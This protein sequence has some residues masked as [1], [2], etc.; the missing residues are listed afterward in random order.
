MVR[1][2]QW[3][4]TKEDLVRLREYEPTGCFVAEVEGAPAGHVF[5]ISYQKLGWIGMLIIRS[6]YRRMGIGESLMLR[7]KQ[8]LQS[9]GAETIKLDAVPE[10]SELY[11]KI[12]FVNEYDSLRF[13][14]YAGRARMCQSQNVSLFKEETIGEIAEFD[15][16]YFGAIRERVLRKLHAA[17]PGLCFAATSNS[18][19]IGYIMCRKADCGYNLGPWVCMPERDNVAA[20]LLAACLK[21]INPAEPVYV[22]VPETNKLAKLTLRRFGFSQYSKA[23]R[24]TFGQKLQNECAEGIFGIGGPMKG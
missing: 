14:G 15:S 8:Y 5:S 21:Q 23:I 16:R 2:E 17:F 19:V 22:G 18:E 1:T 6:R 10:I 4:V 11:R 24:M 7:A 20:D 9:V 12:G 13:E 3:N